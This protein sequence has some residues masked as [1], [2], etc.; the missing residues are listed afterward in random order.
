MF[1]KK[2]SMKRL[3]ATMVV[4]ALTSG[5]VAGTNVAASVSVP[6]RHPDEL[7]ECIEKAEAAIQ[8]KDYAEATNVYTEIETFF[9]GHQ[10][11]SAVRIGD[12][13][14]I[15]GKTNEAIRAYQMALKKYPLGA[16]GRCRAYDK[17]KKLK[18][19]QNETVDRT[20]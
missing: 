2:E 10:P 1:C 5:A 3:L 15:Q 20:R 12:I 17:L 6:Q 14:L 13:L 16:G 18:T 9:P 7:T 19:D 4:C 8:K 11:E